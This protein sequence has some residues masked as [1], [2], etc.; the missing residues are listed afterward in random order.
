MR[1]LLD[2]AE[3]TIELRLTE[4][5]AG[6]RVA[7]PATVDIGESGRLLGVDLALP[8]GEARY[9]VVEPARGELARS[10]EVMVRVAFGPDGAIAAVELPRRGGGHELSYPSGNRCWL[11]A[12]DGRFACELAPVEAG[13]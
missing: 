13:P 1:L 8:D 9:V 5:A 11:P 7:C 6:E 4:D 10:A 2:L 3:N 12:R